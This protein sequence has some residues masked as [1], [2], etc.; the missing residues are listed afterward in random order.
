MIN[1]L[2]THIKNGKTM[3]F[4]FDL[5][6]FLIAFKTDLKMSEATVNYFN[7]NFPFKI[8]QID[9][10]KTTGH[11]RVEVLQQDLSFTAFWNAYSYK[12][13]NKAR[14][15]KLWKALKDTDKAKAISY[16]KRYNNNLLL[17]PG[18]QRL[19][20]ETYLSQKRFNNE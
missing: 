13:G 5:N 9:H 6:G 16:I 14:A 19:Y 17:T 10:F 20:P 4:T 2:V 18:I 8:S 15:E 12:V 1:Y 7:A 3:L 11:F